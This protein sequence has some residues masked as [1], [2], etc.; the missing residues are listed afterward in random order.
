MNL[1]NLTKA[2]LLAELRE[3]DDFS[4]PCLGLIDE[5]AAKPESMAL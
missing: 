5:V 2:K 1:A 4:E 3:M